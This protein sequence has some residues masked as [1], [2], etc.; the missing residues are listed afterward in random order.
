MEPT[1]ELRIP[2]LRIFHPPEADVRSRE[3]E[4]RR[5]RV[6]KVRIRSPWL[7]S[8][9]SP[10]VGGRYT[11]SVTIFETLTGEPTGDLLEEGHVRTRTSAYALEPGEFAGRDATLRVPADPSVTP[12]AAYVTGSERFYLVEWTGPADRVLETVELGA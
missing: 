1:E 2:G 12:R 11:V 10:G 3:L 8:E 9:S 7:E 6:R 5:Y 4:T